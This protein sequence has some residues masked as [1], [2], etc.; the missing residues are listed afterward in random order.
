[1]T[2][3]LF[4][5]L[6]V[7]GE[8]SVTRYGAKGDGS[9]D[10]T[11]AIQAAID[12][13]YAAGGRAVYMPRGNY[14][15]SSPLFLDPPGNL[16]SSLSNPTIFNFSLALVGENGLPNHEGFGTTIRPVSSS[17]VALW[18]GTGQGMLVKGLN[19]IP[20]TKNATRAAL[21]QAGV[22]ISIPSGTGGA[23]RTRIEDCWVEFYYRNYATGFNRDTLGDSNTFLNCHSTNGYIGYHFMHSQNDINSLFDCKGNQNKYQVLSD[24]G[25]AVNIDGGIYANA[26]CYFNKFAISAVSGLTGFSENYF[27]HGTANY[28]FTCTVASPDNQIANGDY[29]V[30]TMMT[31]NFGIVPLQFVSYS[32]GTLTLKFYAPWILANWGGATPVNLSTLTDIAA[33]LAAVATLY[34]AERIVTFKGPGIHARGVH[35]E[36]PATV[37]QLLDTTS[38]TPGDLP[39]TLENI[40]LNYYPSGWQYENSA[41]ATKAVYLCQQ[42]FPFIT[43]GQSPFSLKRSQFNQPAFDTQ[44]FM[45]ETYRA[46]CTI[47]EMGGSILSPNVREIG[48]GNTI[49]GEQL[50]QPN[51]RWQSRAFGSIKWDVTPFQAR[52][53]V[54]TVQEYWRTASDGQ[55][56]HFGYKPAPYA[57]PTIT[58]VHLTALQGV[59]PAIGTYPLLYGQIA[60][61]VTEWD[62]GAP[63]GK[64]WAMSNHQFW[65][66]GQDLTVNWSYKGQSTVVTLSDTSLMFLGLKIGLNNGS[67][68]W[69]VVTGVYP[70]SGYITVAAAVNDSVPQLHGTSTAVY[71]GSVI[72]Q[73]VYAITQY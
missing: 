47:S 34:C 65:S 60:Y 70:A 73:E 55:S 43:A 21:D 10:D 7:P 8:F 11:A 63:G 48:I 2:L 66:Y 72:K 4:S 40:F 49:Q 22:G 69:Y 45:I 20:A 12:A 53:L 61:R 5:G 1:M 67:L 37:T 57:T 54:G 3:E 28:T 9:T 27:G 62:S 41:T 30:F 64:L 33:E 68:F 58:P 71:T 25:R 18:V 31:V 19:I 15:T 14:K 38:V 59:L 42:V 23:S 13:A 56:P 52:G 6:G 24:A 36:N 16:R 17:F 50:A 51:A 44:P 35:I 29:D 32:A 39:A 26:Q 46:D